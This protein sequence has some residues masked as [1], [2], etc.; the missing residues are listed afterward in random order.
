MI[1]EKKCVGD[2]NTEAKINLVDCPQLDFLALIFQISNKN[3]PCDQIYEILN[4]LF[5]GWG[6]GREG[7]KWQDK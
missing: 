1:F 3:K 7:G 4:R 2:L 6:Y 5:N